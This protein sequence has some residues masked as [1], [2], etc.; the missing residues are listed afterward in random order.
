MKGSGSDVIR[1]NKLRVHIRIPEAQNIRI[2][3]QNI[4]LADPLL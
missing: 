3:I 4:G 2:R 1:T